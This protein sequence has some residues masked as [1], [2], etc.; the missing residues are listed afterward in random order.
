[1][2]HDANHWICANFAVETGSTTASR[3]C[4]YI[5]RFN[6]RFIRTICRALESEQTRLSDMTSDPAPEN[7]GTTVDR[8][9]PLIRTYVVW[10]AACR[11]GVFGA[12]DA[13]GG[14]LQDM[15][16]SLAKVFTLLC[17]QV[18]RNQEGL[19]SCPY[20][21]PEDMIVR[22]LRPL[23]DVVVPE[24]CRFH[25]AEDGQM[26]PRL[27]DENQQLPAHHE[28]WARILDILR[29]AY[30][31]AE[32]STVPI[33]YRIEQ[34]S[35]VFEFQ[36]QHVQSAD[37][38]KRTPM[39]AV[40]ES[41]ERRPA[42]PEAQKSHAPTGSFANPLVGTEQTPPPA[43]P[44]TQAQEQRAI[45][46]ADQNLID[47]LAPFL[48]PPTPQHQ[49]SSKETSYGMHTETAMDVFGGH[50]QGEPSPLGSGPSR[51]LEPLPWGWVFTP[52]PHKELP[53]P[54]YGGFT[55]QNNAAPS[56][57]NMLTGSDDP[58]VSP[59]RYQPNPMLPQAQR[60]LHQTTNHTATE[61]TH[62][63]QLLQSFGITNNAPC[64]SS[65]SNWSHATPLVHNQPPA[66]AWASKSPETRLPMS[67]DPT[68]FSDMSSLYHGTPANGAP[69]GWPVDGVHHHEQN[70]TPSSQQFQMNSRTTDYDSAILRS[71][72]FGK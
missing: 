70:Q 46:D 52:T 34:D 58:F 48:R 51:K 7:T 54:G 59:T 23:R 8:L 16:W 68:T 11:E 31:L 63:N 30:F 21:L 55:G 50:G 3:F 25:C 61:D 12:A 56:P 42:A 18:Y 26:K 22:G 15:L 62:R 20:L 38:Q 45:E 14:A 1:M 43:R 4:H 10:L 66:A 49:Q 64:A 17:A 28:T 41:E 13:L 65:F 53:S 47:M 9:L 6:L 29:G 24:A 39:V 69:Y 71:A 27:Q 44:T 37:A 57:R 33:G 60:P 72:Y 5:L 36:P 32:D 40:T 19:V 2:D 67:T 35:L